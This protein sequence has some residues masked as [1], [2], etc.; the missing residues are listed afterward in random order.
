MNEPSHDVLRAARLASPLGP[1]F[2]VVDARG[3][4]V[5][6]DF[7]G[8]TARDADE[9]ALE[10]RYARSR[11]SV[12]WEPAALA[13]VAEALEAY[14][15]GRLRRFRL[16]LAPEGTPFQR[17]VWEALVRV[18][19]GATTSYGELARAIGRPGAA[20]AVGRANALNPIS[21]VVP[22]HRVVG[23]GGALTG[24]AG[25]LERKR[26]LLALE[27]G[28]PV[29]APARTGRRTRATTQ[30]SA[31]SASRAR[32]KSGSRLSAAS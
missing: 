17:V 10:Q 20:R 30:S 26:A 3:A 24:Y 1:L 25:G 9:A 15:E 32:S 2:A 21:I 14:F 19:W 11:R 31:S 18:P 13:S 7:V 28:A 5:R 23:S 4:L 16:P 8:T 27:S 22:C 6:L 12:R 29:A